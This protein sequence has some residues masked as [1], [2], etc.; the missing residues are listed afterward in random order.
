MERYDT[1][2]TIEHHLIRGFR[3]VVLAVEDCETDHNRSE[4]HAQYQVID[5]EGCEDWLC[6]YDVHRVS[7]PFV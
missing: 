5:P 4:P 2:D 1:G 6:A 3:M 7:R